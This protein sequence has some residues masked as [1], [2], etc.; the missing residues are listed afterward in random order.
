M[1]QTAAIHL[2]QLPVPVDAVGAPE[3]GSDV[4]A[5]ML[6]RLGV[7]Y[8]AL[9]PGSSFRG[10][11]DSLVNYLGNRHPSIILCNHEEVAISVAHGFAKASQRPIAAAVHSNVGL[12]HASMAIFN[13]W[14]DRVPIFVL[15]GTG[16]L[17]ST[18]RRPW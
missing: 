15:G 11:H 1:V 4:V 9:T 8:I 12:L 2:E 6:E 16:P 7:E 10:L 18:Q 14:V 3:W 5:A 13:A 17:D